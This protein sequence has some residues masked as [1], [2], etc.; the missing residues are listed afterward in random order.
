MNEKI[1]KRGFFN[2]NPIFEFIH[3]LPAS[4]RLLF[5][6]VLTLVISSG[7]WSLVLWND[8]HLHTVPAR[9]GVVIEGMVGN[10][11]F[12]NP[13]LANTRVDKDLTNLVFQGLVKINPEGEIVPD[14]A[15]TITL[16]EANDTYTITMRQDATFHDGRPVTAYDVVFTYNLIQNPELLSPLRGN[17]N[18]VIVEQED[19]FTIT[20][21]FNEPYYPFL[22]NL[23]VGIL[24][25]H[26]WRNIPVNDMAFNIKNLEPIGSGTYYINNSDKTDGFIS[27]L[28]LKAVDSR[29][30]PISD[31]FIRLFANQE[32]LIKQLN[33]REIDATASISDYNLNLINIH[34]YSHTQIPLPRVTAIVFNQNRSEVLRDKN[35]REALD[36]LVDR[37]KIISKAT[38]KTG[39]P[40]TTPIPAGYDMIESELTSSTETLTKEDATKVAVHKLRQGGWEPTEDGVWKRNTAGEDLILSVTLKTLDHPTFSVV[41]DEIADMWR[42]AGIQVMVHKFSSNDFLDGVARPRD[43][44]AVLYGMDLGRSIDL[45]PF[46]HSSQQ[47]DPGLNLAQYTSINADRNLELLRTTFDTDSRVGIKSEL[48]SEIGSELPAIFLYTPTLNYITKNNIITTLPSMIQTVSD[49]WDTVNYWYSTTEKVWPWIEY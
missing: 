17:W 45:Y 3:K 16:N 42:K 6:A 40:N 48:I 13:T 33:N 34:E 46:W 20:I 37:Q 47:T 22:D 5:H 12:I 10:A 19:I 26:I 39:I 7:I 8:Q 23:T 24:P 2:L 15:K 28:H 41:A 36:L 49:R 31:L 43:F 30:T 35:V 4:D 9:H 18:N 25:S 27:E 44:E 11:R 1:Q 38:A 21:T 32:E 14:L 29:T